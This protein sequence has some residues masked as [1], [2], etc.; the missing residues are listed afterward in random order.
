M[1]YYLGVKLTELLVRTIKYF[2]IYH[3]PSRTLI[4][5]LAPLVPLETQCA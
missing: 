5:P 2:Y 3:L 1:L 4:T